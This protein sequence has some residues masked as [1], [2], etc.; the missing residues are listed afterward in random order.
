M[1]QIALCDDEVKQRY[2]L[3]KIIEKELSDRK[4]D[5]KILEYGSGESL[6]AADVCRF[7]LIFLDVE[8]AGING[9]ETA[10]RIRMQNTGVCLVFV[11]GY[12]DYVFD[13]Y[14]VRA[15]QYI[16][17]PYKVEQIRTV[18][19]TALKQLHER[20]GS[21]FY[22]ETDRSFYKIPWEQIRYF[23]SELRKIHLSAQEREY[24]FYGRLNDLQSQV[25]SYFFRVHQRYL[26]N[27]YFVQGIENQELILPDIRLPISRSRSKDALIAFAK[28]MLDH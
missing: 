8:M 16:L 21:F 7:D 14:E 4:I 17:K 9:I 28:I 23:S 25:P 12:A 22:L 1:I 6:L 27:F 2:Q 3:Q 26:V 13:G 15:L 11:T 10:R 20:S 5:Y 18:L 24:E 19:D